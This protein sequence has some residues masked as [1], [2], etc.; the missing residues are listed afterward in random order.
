MKK[1]S[2]KKIKVTLD[3]VLKVTQQGFERV[4]KRMD[5]IELK[6]VTKD[7]LHNTVTGLENRLTEKI[8]KVE[9]KVTGLSGRVEALE[10]TV[11]LIKTKLAI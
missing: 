10:D 1:K 11:R 3:D 2:S 6:M 7:E 9:F 5:E 8:E 4:E